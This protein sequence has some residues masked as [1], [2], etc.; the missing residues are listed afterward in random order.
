MQGAVCESVDEAKPRS[1]RFPR[2]ELQVDQPLGPVHRH[3]QRGEDRDRDHRASHPDL[4]VK[5]VE[6][7]DLVR[8]GRRVATVAVG[9]PCLHPAHHG[10]DRALRHVAIPEQRRNHLTD[11]ACLTNVS[12]LRFH[13]QCNHDVA[14]KLRNPGKSDD[15]RRLGPGLGRLELSDPA[16]VLVPDRAHLGQL[17]EKPCVYFSSRRLRSTSELPG[18]ARVSLPPFSTCCSRISAPM[19][20]PGVVSDT[21]TLDGEWRLFKR[22]SKM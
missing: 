7:Q 12:R 9:N 3:S 2:H 13:E 19:I 17:R 5:A 8:L 20:R 18:D 21:I 22:C 14:H 1:A 4:P 10:R 11:P 16:G 15:A 6:I